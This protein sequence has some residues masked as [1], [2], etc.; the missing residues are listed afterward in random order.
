MY[1][2]LYT[3]TRRMKVNQSINHCKG[4]ATKI[5]MIEDD[6]KRKTVL[7]ENGMKALAKRDDNIPIEGT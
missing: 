2:D 1:I 6:I 4:R 3:H 5:K 7:N